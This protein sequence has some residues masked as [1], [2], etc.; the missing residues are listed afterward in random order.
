MRTFTEV[1]EEVVKN[2]NQLRDDKSTYLLG[3]TVKDLLRITTQVYSDECKVEISI[4]NS[5]QP[6]ESR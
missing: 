1:Y 4:N 5:R 3:D 2:Y 6:H